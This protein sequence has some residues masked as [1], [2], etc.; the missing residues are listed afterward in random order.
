MTVLIAC[1][2]CHGSGPKDCPRC[3]GKGSL[4]STEVHPEETPQHGLGLPPL[5]GREVDLRKPEVSPEG[6]LDLP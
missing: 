4:E 3:H 1:P 6:A 5:R 2:T